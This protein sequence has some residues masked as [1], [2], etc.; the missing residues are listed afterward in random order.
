MTK[1][2]ISAL[3][4]LFLAGCATAPL[5]EANI[6]EATTEQLCQ[7]I[8]ADRTGAYLFGPRGDMANAE[9]RR[10]GTFSDE[11]MS[12]IE[13]ESVRVGMREE[14]ALCA[15]GYYWYGRNVTTY[16]GGTQIQYVFGDGTY[17]PRQYLYVRNGLVSGMQ[18]A[19]GG[20]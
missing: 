13:Q 10:R 19:T 9:L 1:Q 2:P 11:E 7:A 8:M 4:G 16:S 14:A 6:S 17:N 12:L 5:T 20:S 15:W 3:L 18:T